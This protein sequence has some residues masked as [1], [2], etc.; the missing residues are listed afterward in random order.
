MLDDVSWILEF[1]NSS[2]QN[3]PAKNFGSALMNDK[4]TV[5]MKT[6]K[7]EET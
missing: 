1:Y 5:I 6:K 3:I 4:F 2:A 7:K